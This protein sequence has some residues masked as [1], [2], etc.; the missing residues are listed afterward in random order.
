M[1]L[2]FAT[3]AAGLLAVGTAHA[4]NR[5][6][7]D[8]DAASGAKIGRAIINAN[9]QIAPAVTCKENGKGSINVVFV[10]PTSFVGSNNTGVNVKF[11][12]AKAFRVL[13]ASAGQ[14]V[15]LVHVKPNS[16]EAAVV[17]GLKTAKHMALEIYDAAGHRYVDDFDLGDAATV[18]QQAIDA[19]G[20]TNWQ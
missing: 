10:M 13:G 9:G 17:V 19:C 14:S 5:F 1:K 2:F 7:P 11:D 16:P 15:Y 4:E 6:E 3:I 12:D 20:D 18:V 8:T